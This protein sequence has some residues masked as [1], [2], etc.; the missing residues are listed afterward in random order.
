MI[1]IAMPWTI[2]G[3]SESNLAN[4]NPVVQIPKE[5][6]HLVDIEW[7]DDEQAKLKVLE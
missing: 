5:N 3:W 1:Q 7:S 2:R 4:W 6:A